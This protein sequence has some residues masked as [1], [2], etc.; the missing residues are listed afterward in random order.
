MKKI[1]IL[2]LLSLS[3]NAKT[4]EFSGTYETAIKKERTT[5]GY[6]DKPNG[7]LYS[8]KNIKVKTKNE[9]ETLGLRV[10]KVNSLL[11]VIPIKTKG[12]FTCIIS[13]NENKCSIKN[14]G[15]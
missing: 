1:I 5:T 4:I 13:E 12:I 14:K 7:C 6:I 10:I 9:C 15:K 3:L 2:L 8:G 11:R